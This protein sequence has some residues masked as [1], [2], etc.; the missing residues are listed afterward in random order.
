MPE[1]P[2]IRRA[3]DRVARAIEGEVAQEVYFGLDRLVPWEGELSGRTVEQVTTRGKGMLTFFE[4]DWVVF[5]HNQL[6]GRWFV[7]PAGQTPRTGRQLRFAVHTEDRSALLYSAS[8]IDVL[9]VDDLDAHP[10]LSKLGPDALDAKV[11]VEQVAA[12]LRSGAFAKRQLAAVLL[13]QGFIA[14]L[15]NYLRC[16]IL[17]AAG[18]HPRASA[19]R[20]NDGTLENLAEQ[21]LVMPRRAYKTGGVTNDPSRVK[22]LKA[23]GARKRAYRHLAFHRAGQACYR[24]DDILVREE[25]GGRR[26]DRCPTCQKEPH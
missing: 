8:T 21:V 17:H 26:C 6:Y 11:T 15:G 25:H 13:D 2:E 20:L 12:R 24:C 18:V 7:K 9:P 3:A 4:G 22:A 1:G 14:G 23:D 5:T 16:E 19:H 10:F